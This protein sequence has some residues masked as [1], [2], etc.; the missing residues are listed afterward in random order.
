MNSE[1]ASFAVDADIHI[2]GPF[3]AGLDAYTA[4]LSTMVTDP[5]GRGMKTK[6]AEATFP[7]MALKHGSNAVDFKM[8]VKVVDEDIMLKHFAGPTF[9]SGDG[10]QVQLFV[11]VDKLTMHVFGVIPLPGK[12]MHKVLACNKAAASATSLYTGA[13]TLRLT[14]SQ[15]LGTSSQNATTY[16]MQCFHAKDQDVVV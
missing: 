16:V 13:S 11:D 12:K 10:E 15:V 7:Q 14:S 2:P 5:V 1:L 3:G 4:T 8:P 6:F 9:S